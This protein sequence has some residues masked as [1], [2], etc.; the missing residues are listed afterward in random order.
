MGKVRRGRER[1]TGKLSDRNGMTVHTVHSR[2]FS[3]RKQRSYVLALSYECSV[4]HKVD[5]PKHFS[6]KGMA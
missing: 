1:G 4:S 2:K 6:E 5:S 3:K